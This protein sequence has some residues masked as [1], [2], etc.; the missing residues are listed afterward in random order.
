MFGQVNLL[1]VLVGAVI[2]MVLGFLWYSP[3]LFGNI[4]LRQIGKSADE[5]SGAAGA[6]ALSFIAALVS[7]L[8]LAF[9]VGAFGA[10]TLGEGLLIGVVVWIGIG[11]TATFVYSVF[12]GPPIGVWLLHG[13][14]QLVVF[15]IE[16][17]LFAVWA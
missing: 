2:S 12:E 3:V 17:A 16:G 13:A 10:N 11:A 1:A 4:W 14:Y 8:V 15:V 5:I 6:Y 9:I 7:A